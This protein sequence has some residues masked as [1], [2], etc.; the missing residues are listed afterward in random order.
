MAAPE[1]SIQIG[2]RVLKNRI[3]MAPTVKFFAGNDGMV[4]DFFVRH[5]ELRALHGAALICVEATCVSEQGRLA[6]TQL[7][8]WRDEQIEGHARIARACHSHGAL[9]IVQLHHGGWNTHPECGQPV[10]PSPYVVRDG[11]EAHV[12]TTE[13]IT[14]IRAD[15]V[16]AAQR[17]QRAGYDGIQVHACHGYLLN[18]FA[19]AYNCRD[20]EYG[21]STENRTRLA[22][23]ILRQ[24]RSACGRDFIISVRVSGLEPTVEESLRTAE[25]YAAAGCDWLQVSNGL[26]DV[27]SQTPDDETHYNLICQLGVRMH[28][29][30]RGRVP[31]SCVNG[32]RTP[33]K[34]RYLLENDLTDTVDLGCGLLADPAFTEA[35]L[36]GADCELCRNCSRCGWRSAACPA[37]KARGV[38]E[39]KNIGCEIP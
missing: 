12:L 15:F 5:Y 7:G 16:A 31:V 30:F 22:C 1:S 10:G 17:A 33:E 14:A 29:H 13:E 39:W 24:I 4:T 26:T 27:S 28:A 2:T 38:N 3:T 36:Y 18:G 21:G 20:D 32:L 37:A 35:I 23:E 6:P 34:V 11:R 9:A 19:S 25:C 8:L